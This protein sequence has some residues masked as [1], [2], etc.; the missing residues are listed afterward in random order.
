M[1]GQIIVDDEDVLALLH[2]LLAD[3]AACI[4]GDVEH[5]RRLGCRGDDDGGV[6]HGAVLAEFL[7]ELGNGGR[8]LAD[9]HVDAEDVL[10]LLVD[11]R[12]DGDGGLARLAVA[13]DELALAL[14]DGDHRVDDLEAGH[15]R[16]VDALAGHD[17]RRD[18]LDGTVAVTLDGTLAVDGL[19][20]RVDH[21]AEHAVA[22]LDLGDLAGALDGLALLDVAVAAEDDDADG[23]LLEVEDH[24]HGAVLELHE[25]GGHG[26]VEALRQR[27]AVAHG[28]DAADVVR[29]DLVLVVLDALFDQ[30]ADLFGSQ[31]HFL[32]A[33]LQQLLFQGPDL[34][35]EG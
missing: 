8:L 2:P 28:D 27:D 10:A 5:R 20:Q 24:A 11:D 29:L 9:G 17:A 1:L 15:E 33:F 19:A 21:A 7:D 12:V 35:L 25:L 13:D 14:A 18:A 31:I 23:L 32:P 34:G 16:L 3:G 22:H 4:R 6:V 26:G 30:S